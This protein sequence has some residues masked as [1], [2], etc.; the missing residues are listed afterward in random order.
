VTTPNGNVVCGKDV[1]AAFA[2]ISRHEPTDAGLTAAWR[3]LCGQF[4]DVFAPPL[5]EGWMGVRGGQNVTI[6]WAN[7]IFAGRP[8]QF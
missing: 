7:F 6:D 3:S 4:S 5:A 1:P 8:C 2:E